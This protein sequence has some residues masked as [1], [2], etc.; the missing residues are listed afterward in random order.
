M[1]EWNKTDMEDVTRLLSSP[2]W[3]L[4]ERFVKEAEEAELKELMGKKDVMEVGKS[5]GRIDALRRVLGMPLVA[6]EGLRDYF[7][8]PSIT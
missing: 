2:G 1:T 6:V 4:L 3:R 5:L 8:L 7:D